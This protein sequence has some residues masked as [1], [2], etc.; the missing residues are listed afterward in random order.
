MLVPKAPVQTPAPAK[1]VTNGFL[2]NAQRDFAMQQG[3]RQLLVSPRTENLQPIDSRAKAHD[4]QNAFAP[5]GNV[6]MRSFMTTGNLLKT[7]NPDIFPPV[8]ANTYNTQGSNFS[9]A[10]V[11][12][13]HEMNSFIRE[14]ETQDIFGIVAPQFTSSL[15]SMPDPGVDSRGLADNS[16]LDQ[17]RY[18]M[19][20]VHSMPQT[21]IDPSGFSDTAVLS[22]ARP[23]W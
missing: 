19:Q 11:A 14:Q 21:G 9:G 4:P 2:F 5:Y 7:I 13:R 6:G 10:Q 23:V 3:G 18:Q 22:Q 16:S 15:P 12:P 20:Q 17:T 1:P 8:L